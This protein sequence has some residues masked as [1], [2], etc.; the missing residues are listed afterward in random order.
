[1][2]ICCSSHP[3]KK[4]ELKSNLLLGVDKK[5]ITMIVLMQAIVRGHITRKHFNANYKSPFIITST[6]PKVNVHNIIQDLFKKLGPFFSS[7]NK[8]ILPSKDLKWENG[9]KINDDATYEGFWNK[10][11]NRSGYCR[12]VWADGSLYEGYIE[13]N[14]A[15][16][17]GRLIHADG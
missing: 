12:Q 6:N 16:G 8:P 17:K 5:T 1:M 4:N 7:V 11:G 15:K 9:K 10:E 2:G 14:K 3:D 13:S